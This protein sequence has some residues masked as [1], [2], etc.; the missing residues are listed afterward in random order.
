MWVV[1]ICTVSIRGFCNRE[2]ANTVPSQKETV[3]CTCSVCRVVYVHV[4]AYA[5]AYACVYVNVYVSVLCDSMFC[6]VVCVAHEA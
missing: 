5:Y 1:R 6:V 4:H 3:L 2:S